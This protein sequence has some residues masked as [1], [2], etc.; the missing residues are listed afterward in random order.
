MFSVLL[1]L[2]LQRYYGEGILD[3]HFINTLPVVAAH[4]WLAS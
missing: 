4:W 1:F 2:S 3:V